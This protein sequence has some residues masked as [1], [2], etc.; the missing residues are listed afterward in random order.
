MTRVI[1][2]DCQLTCIF[3]HLE[4]KLCT[5]L[6][7]TTWWFI[8]SKWFACSLLKL[9]WGYDDIVCIPC[10]VTWTVRDA[11]N[12][13]SFANLVWKLHPARVAY[14]KFCT[15]EMILLC[16]QGCV[17][18]LSAASGLQRDL[19]L[20]RLVNWN[21]SQVVHTQKSN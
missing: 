11:F 2:H 20:V 3:S 12:S 16:G 8:C 13:G 10:N 21:T 7:C 19:G 1:S 9:A 15:Y 4:H 14:T 6:I 18:S 17:Y 5:Q